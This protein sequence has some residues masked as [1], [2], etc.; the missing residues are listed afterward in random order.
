MRTL[1]VIVTSSLLVTTIGCAIGPLGPPLGL[2]PGLDQLVFL[3]LI[4]IA[5]LFLW[6]RTQ[7]YFRKNSENSRSNHLKAGME[8]VAERYARGEINRDEY[9]KML[10]DLR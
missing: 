2:G 3:G 7:R 1:A 10:D 4:F 9:L 6:P 5:I 8:T